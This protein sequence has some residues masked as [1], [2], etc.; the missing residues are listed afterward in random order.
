MLFRKNRMIRSRRLS[1]YL[2]AIILAA[3]PLLSPMLAG[4]AYANCVIDYACGPNETPQ[5]CSFDCPG[6]CGDAFCN[7][8]WE[9]SATC[10]D[11]C[12]QTCGDSLCTG[13]EDVNTCQQDCPGTCGDGICNP[14]FES[15]A[16]CGIFAFPPSPA[17]D[18]TCGDGI[19]Q[20]YENDTN[21]SADCREDYFMGSTCGDGLDNDHDGLIDCNDPGCDFYVSCLP[22]VCGDNV[23]AATE[24]NADCQFDCYCGDTICKDDET[25]GN[26]PFDCGPVGGVC[27]DGTANAGE[28]CDDSNAF[29]NDGCDQ[30]LAADSEAFGPDRLA[31]AVDPCPLSY[32]DSCYVGT[33]NNRGQTGV[34]VIPRT[35]N[36][37][38][39]R[40]V[41]SEDFSANHFNVTIPEGSITGEPV[42]VMLQDWSQLQGP[43]DA[44]Y[45]N[46]DP[47]SYAL[48]GNTR[49]MVNIRSVGNQSLTGP[50]TLEFTY[51]TNA[52]TSPEATSD[53]S[54]RQ[55]QINGS[56][57]MH[58]Y[59]DTYWA[60]VPVAPADRQI[61][62]GPIAADHDGTCEPGEIC[63]FRFTIRPDTLAGLGVYMLAIPSLS[64]FDLGNS[65]CDDVN[66]CTIDLCDLTTGT[67]CHH[68][69]A[70][71]GTSCNDGNVCTI[72]DICNGSLAP[73][74]CAGV[75]DASTCPGWQADDGACE[76]DTCNAPCAGPNDKENANNS[77]ADCNPRCNNGVCENQN[78]D[79]ENAAPSGALACPADCDPI[80]GNGI[81]E[82]NDASDSDGTPG[83][84][85]ESSLSCPQD[86]P[87]PVCGNG[88]YE[89][90][91]NPNSKVE[92]CDEV[93]VGA[94]TA[95]CDFDCHLINPTAGNGY[96]EFNEGNNF[97]N[98]NKADCCGANKPGNTGC[99]GP[100]G[101]YGPTSSAYF[102]PEDCGERGQAP[103]GSRLCSN[104]ADDDGDGKADCL[105][106]DCHSDPACT[107]VENCSNGADDDLDGKVDCM[108]PDCIGLIGPGGNACCDPINPITCEDGDLC[109]ADSCNSADHQC[110]RIPANDSDGD[111]VCDP[112]D[113]CVA[114]PNPGSGQT[115]NA[116][117]DNLP[118]ACDPCPNDPTNNCETNCTDGIDNNGANGADCNDPSCQIT[119]ACPGVVQFD[120]P[121]YLIPEDR[122]RVLGLTFNPADPILI[123]RQFGSYGRISFR[124][125]TT[126]TTTDPTYMDA[127]P[128]RDYCYFTK[129]LASSLDTEFLDNAALCPTGDVRFAM[130][131]GM[132]NLVIGS[133][134]VRDSILEANQTYTLNITEV[135]CD[136]TPP[137]DGVDEGT[138]TTY[139]QVAPFLRSTAKRVILDNEL[140]GG[141]N[142]TSSELP[143]GSDSGNKTVGCAMDENATSQ[144]LTLGQAINALA[145]LGFGLIFWGFSQARG[146]SISTPSRT[147]RYRWL[148][149]FV[150][151]LAAASLQGISLRAE[152]ADGDADGIEDSLDNCPLIAN[153]TQTDLDSDGLGDT[154]DNCPTISNPLQGDF[155]HNGIGDACE[156][157][158]DSNAETSCAVNLGIPG[159]EQQASNYQCG[160]G[161]PIC[162][163]FVKQKKCDEI[164]F[165]AP[166]VT[167]DRGELY[168]SNSVCQQ[169]SP[170]GPGLSSASS[171]VCQVRYLDEAHTLYF[172]TVFCAGPI[173]SNACQ[174]RDNF[175]RLSYQGASIGGGTCNLQGPDAG[176]CAC[177]AACNPSNCDDGDPCSFDYCDQ[178]GC[179]HSPAADGA[180]C[181]DGNACTQGDVCSS[182]I[183]G[184]VAA[185]VDDGNA[186]TADSCDPATGVKHTPVSVDDGNACTAD[187]CDPATGVKHT[188]INVD[189]GNACTA[190]SCDPATGVKHTPIGVDDGNACTTDSCDPATGVVHTPVGV[191]DGNACTANSCNPA[192]GV[193]HTP[194]GVDDGNA[195][196]TDSCNPATGL[197][198]TP[199]SV[200][201]GNA[202]TTDSCNPATGVV[203]TP[204]N[205]DDGN[206]CTT[207][208][209]NPATGV[210][211]TPVSVD[212]GNACTTDSC[213]PATGVV[214]TPVDVDDGNACTTDSCNPATGPI[215]TA[216]NPNDGD[217]CT[218]D[219]CNPAIGP[220]HTPVNPDDGNPC[221]VDSCNSATGVHHDPVNVNDG[222]ACTVDSCNPSDGSIS[223]VPVPVDDGDGCTA[224]ACEPSTGTVSHNPIDGG[225]NDGDGV[226]Q[227]FDNCPGVPNAD[228]LDV[229]NDGVGDACEAGE[230][231][232]SVDFTGLPNTTCANTTTVKSMTEL[233]AWLA[234]PKNTNLKVLK[235]RNNGSY[236][237]GGAN[238]AI[239]T[240]CRVELNPD[241]PFH[242]VGNVDIQASEI[243]MRNDVLC[244]PNSSMRLRAGNNVEVKP[245]SLVNLSVE[246]V[247]PTILYR[248]DV[249]MASGGEVALCG[250][251]IE[252]RPASFMDVDRVF[253]H[254]TDTLL[255]RGDIVG[256]DQVRL[257]S[258]NSLTLRPA[259]MIG[260]AYSPVRNLDIQAVGHFEDYGDISADGDVRMN[261]NSYKLFPSH[262]FDVDGTCTLSGQASPGSKPIKGHCVPGAN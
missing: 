90:G 233:Q 207:D 187:S 150:L 260:S 245:A 45:I 121:S 129:P 248:G 61:L 130:E 13:T 191:D 170:N 194:V 1:R 80:C 172:S 132:A 112:K 167:G 51:Y 169:A 77:P 73:N 243:L 116:D 65:Y 9:T 136:T 157:G 182:G 246:V 31:N 127:T 139:N 57:L 33:Q 54:I 109:T 63:T 142:T 76:F 255:V 171:G 221:T 199:V 148:R 226:C 134:V 189:D 46:T 117:G 10:P 84:A 181:E 180:S 36:S 83:I 53:R 166:P 11:D 175:K 25:A 215:H 234:G 50:I 23:C 39:V 114:I 225:D 35:V 22:P 67:S 185:S 106:P 40:Y 2:A 27:G 70:S 71:S 206:A 252:M 43:P 110:K 18:C 29:P 79:T 128:D 239:A 204:V 92:E 223:H 123:T 81:C 173:D 250:N 193:V 237:F 184:G 256:A 143:P 235:H 119:P 14:Y 151:L 145:L 138:C 16:N 242:N 135:K 158:N 253:M 176:S 91:S 41:R 146:K 168:Y 163:F 224:D 202:C 222:N 195:C 179:H 229:D 102:C 105:D 26:C 211:H 62:E 19:C 44:V 126:E 113:T 257:I 177:S 162:G 154:C 218:V 160:T 97:S 183:C 249:S 203:H 103:D 240:A 3:L 47:P 108:D 131:P 236:N 156:C 55:A 93:A 133:Q 210:V 94:S 232:C 118:D 153:P 88:V 21:C 144:G 219:S 38:T 95:T 216:V 78:G 49:A 140:E 258:G 254:A 196:T 52:L 69:A 28:Q 6:D 200:D 34:G 5:D 120:A 188:P 82:Y 227:D 59:Q 48:N 15:I 7:P 72:A 192:T 164:G 213:N 231:A 89:P 152:A 165:T 100:E 147:R 104:G 197:T 24:H 174:S 241:A 212:D 251:Y 161:D 86:C 186:C 4:R 190:D 125:V 64:C 66:P 228:Q 37:A 87:N 17:N 58:Y 20:A 141:A 201:D 244:S 8:Y 205:V 230:D 198:H 68:N 208:S 214:H 111:G 209:C 155:N 30:C 85:N 75:Y 122:G 220:V 32:G 60:P 42:Q 124:V 217:A 96:C 159:K 262:S 107:T 99:S 101:V 149:L 12:P 247:S 178:N 98:Y 74:A 259:N 115:A 261:S 56:Y 238:L 137:F